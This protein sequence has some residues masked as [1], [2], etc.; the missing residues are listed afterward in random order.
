MA[1]F[2]NQATLTY[3]NTVTNSNIVTGEIVDSITAVKTAVSDSY[4]A[5]DTVTYAVSL[6]NIGS[7]AI[8]GITVT[9]D[10]GAYTFGSSSL[11][12]LTYRDGTVRYYVN[13][14]LQATPTVT[15]DNTL[16]ISG[17]SIP[18]GGNAIILYSALVNSFAPLSSGGT[19]NNTAT[20]TAAGI[21]NPITATETINA[22]TGA[23]LSIIKAISPQTITENSE[24][25]YTFTIN[26]Y[27]S[28]AVAAGDNAIVTDT[29]DPVLRGLAV[30][31]NG[32]AWTAPTNYTYSEATGLFATTAGQ[33]TVP[34]ATYTQAGSGEWTVQPGTAV[35]TVKGTIA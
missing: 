21:A 16:T 34:A 26:N 4:S 3:N 24:I 18:A 2:T 6:V 28:T 5:S 32:A 25:T 35:L 22:A 8:T 23:R 1:I 29:F 15:S 19:I 30:S 11:I 7:S 10:L 12:P 31:F 9:D 14:V 33:L 20:V 27:G 17:I 13:G